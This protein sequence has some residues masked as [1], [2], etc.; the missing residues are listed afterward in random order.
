MAEL[1]WQFRFL[2]SVIAAAAIVILVVDLWAVCWLGMSQT[3]S[4]AI[5]CYSLYHPWVPYL[6]CLVIGF[7]SGMGVAH[8]FGLS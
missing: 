6:T 4:Q 5:Y 8:F 3:I 2:L 7:V 1:P